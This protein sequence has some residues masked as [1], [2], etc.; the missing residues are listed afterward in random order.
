MY[1]NNF[2]LCH[3]VQ[4]TKQTLTTIHIQ[5]QRKKVAIKKSKE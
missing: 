1:K 4:N 5:Q 3:N 2:T